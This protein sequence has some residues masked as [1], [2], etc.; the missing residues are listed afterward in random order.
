MHRLPAPVRAAQ[1]APLRIG[2]LGQR[3]SAA[4]PRHRSGDAMRKTPTGGA[5]DS[6]V[7]GTPSP[8]TAAP[9][10]HRTQTRWRLAARNSPV[11]RVGT[12]TQERTKC[13]STPVPSRL[14]IVSVSRL[15]GEPLLACLPTSTPYSEPSGRS[16]RISGRRLPLDPARCLYGPLRQNSSASRPW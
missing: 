16:T 6:A 1:T 5:A 14:E 12:T 11:E 7:V 9:A 15:T 4:T 10:G 3:R 2:P 8:A 13:I